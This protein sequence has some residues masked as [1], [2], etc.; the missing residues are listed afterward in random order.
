MQ[1]KQ[2]RD[3]RPVTSEVAGSSPVV[4]AIPFNHLESLPARLFGV[5]GPVCTRCSAG[6]LAVPLR[7]FERLRDQ[8]GRSADGSN[9]VAL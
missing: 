9:G 5:L 8:I 4:P 7:L 3:V 6:A 1:N 2:W